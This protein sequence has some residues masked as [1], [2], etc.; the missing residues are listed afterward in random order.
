MKSYK[1]AK[2]ML[3]KEIGEDFL[4]SRAWECADASLLLWCKT[5]SGDIALYK[6]DNNGGFRP[7]LTGAE[8]VAALDNAKPIPLNYEDV[9]DSMSDFGR[10][11]DW[12]I[13]EAWEMPD[14]FIFVTVPAHAKPPHFGGV[15]H[16]I[17]RIDGDD[18][19]TG[20]SS[21]LSIP[22]AARRIV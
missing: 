12:R 1:E 21:P 20:T 16:S 3:R 18:E 8:R 2:T 6:T 5:K 22:P 11:Q 4:V 9:L 15:C 19:L 17:S 14:K 7:V 10:K 13:E